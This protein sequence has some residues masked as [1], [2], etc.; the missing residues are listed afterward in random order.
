MAVAM[1]R[2]NRDSDG[3]CRPHARPHACERVE[4][5]AA[6]AR[7]GGWSP[8]GCFQTSPTGIR[9]RRRPAEPQS[10]LRLASGS[11]GSRRSWVP[12]VGHCQNPA[13]IRLAQGSRRWR[14]VFGHHES[15]GQ[16]RPPGAKA[17]KALGGVCHQAQLVFYPAARPNGTTAAP[18][19]P[20]SHTPNRSKAAR[21]RSSAVPR[22]SAASLALLIACAHAARR[23]RARPRVCR[24]R[25][26]TKC[27]PA[28]QCRE[29]LFS[30]ACG[31][32]WRLTR[33]GRGGG[34]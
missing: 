27:S 17:G 21:C 8:P 15:N 22:R 32:V 24:R 30:R 20:A 29:T 19:S 6:A 26:L 3:S 23:C 34:T 4:R 11:S 12:F 13:G 14:S 28:M 16:R 9:S 7:H 2:T 10:G 33:A 5:A 1:G 25:C 18:P 31:S